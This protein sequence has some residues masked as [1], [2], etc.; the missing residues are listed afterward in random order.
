MGLNSIKKATFS[1]A[2]LA[3]LA[4]GCGATSQKV[5]DETALGYRNIPLTQEKDVAPPPVEF[6]K[7]APGEAKIFERSYENAPPMIP[8]SV[9]GLL[10][11]TKN[12]NSCLG[13]HLPSVAKSV[14][15]TP[16]SKTHF[17]DFFAS[18]KEELQKFK[19]ASKIHQEKD[20]I[21]PQRF[22][23]SQC[24][25]PQANVDPLVANRFKPE[26]RNDALKSRSNLLDK[27]NEGIE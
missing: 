17:K 3:L 10:P 19:G 21:A 18:T 11:I 2:L 13:C 16:M 8:H 15:A 5:I 23:C 7:A 20:D 12:N 4:A 26:F 1:I 22:N 6:I 24:H 27:L 9:D 25:A 14:G